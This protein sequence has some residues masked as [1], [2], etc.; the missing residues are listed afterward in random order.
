MQENLSSFP[1]ILSE[2]IDIPRIQLIIED[3]Y[4]ITNLGIGV[5]DTNGNVLLNIGWQDICL[6]FHRVHPETLKR[7]IESNIYLSRD[8]K[9]NNFKF[10]KCKNNIW[11]AST[12]IIVFGQHLGNIFY[13]QFFFDDEEIDYETFRAYAREFGFDEKQYIDALN[14]VPRWSKN[15]LINVANFYSKIAAYISEFVIV[16][17]NLKQTVSSNN[18]ALI[19]LKEAHEKNLKLLEQSEKKSK[20]IEALLKVANLVFIKRP[21]SHITKVIC[22]T[23]KELVGAKAGFVSLIETRHMGN[24]I[25][26]MDTGDFTCNVSPES[27]LPYCFLRTTA[28]AITHPFMDNDFAQRPNKNL[29]LGHIEI[30]NILLAP[31]KLDHDNIG[32]IGLANKENGFDSSDMEIV[33]KISSITA[34]ALNNILTFQSLEISELNLKKTLDKLTESR[35]LLQIALEASHSGA[36]QWDLQSDE[37]YWTEELWTLL[38][39]KPHSFKLSINTWRELVHPFDIKKF[40]EVVLNVKEGNE[41]FSLEWRFLDDDNTIRWLLS[42]GL[43]ISNQEE[44]T[45][46]VTGITLDITRRKTA[47]LSL[48]EAKEK[49]ETANSIKDLFLANMS[50][51]LR[52]PMNAVMGFVD[53]LETTSLTGQQRVY[54]DGIRHS[55]ETLIKLLSDILDLSNIQSNKVQLNSESF[56]LR[57]TLRDIINIFIFIAGQKGIKQELFIEDTIPDSLIGDSKKLAQIITILLNNALKY[58]EKGKIGL[59]VFK[60]KSFDD[61]VQL[62]F[63]VKDTGIGIPEDKQDVIFDSFMQVDMSLTRKYQGAG[64]GLTICKGLVDLMK[65]NV[66]VESEL[67]V[68]SSFHFIIDFEL[69]KSEVNLINDGQII[70]RDCKSD[71]KVLIVEDNALNQMVL[72]NLLVKKNFIVDVCNNGLESI[73]ALEKQRY[74]LVLMDIQMPI[75]NGDEAL[76]IIRDSNSKVLD[77]N[78]PIIAV[79]AHA[80]EGD[81]ERFL[82]CG[83]NAYLPK[84]VKIDELINI[85]DAITETR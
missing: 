10:Y 74:D 56:S 26:Y 2:I 38:K 25:G 4:K 54:I 12:P 31:I 80:L 42:R 71:L 28:K 63:I 73:H 17:F 22:D 1:I 77:H 85:I 67:G 9:E 46:H 23:S 27:S 34:F 65:G 7:C 32:I 51:E 53:L 18:K 64:L 58:T 19:E 69:D 36:W 48:L 47:E 13:G 6:K 68:G 20:E 37:I 55:S 45:K 75:M 66:W 62:H 78:V 49:A 44:K 60:N 24:D 39:I 8:V 5:V 50:H 29:P 16:N 40:D 33:K 21:L 70:K 52:T 83:F 59:H 72:K 57:K 61:K 79:T 82:G 11:V 35:K 76:K 84:P 43:V 15:T 41:I 3:L 14:K 81:K 30:K